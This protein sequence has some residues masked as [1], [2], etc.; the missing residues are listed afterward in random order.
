MSGLFHPSSLFSSLP[1]K[2]LQVHVSDLYLLLERYCPHH[3]SYQSQ[4][5]T[6]K[7][8]ERVFVAFVCICFLLLCFGLLFLLGLL[9]FY[10]GGGCCFAL[11]C[12]F[13]FLFGCFSFRGFG[14]G[15]FVSLGKPGYCRISASTTICSLIP[16][17]KGI[18][19][20]PPMYTFVPH[21][22]LEICRVLSRTNS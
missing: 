15:R 4:Q 20:N 6:K 17:V 10:I 2:L 1:T 12:C 13:V 7:G 14:E 8:K 11:F 3:K 16:S 18:Y 5:W 19:S 9:F 21:Y 22:A